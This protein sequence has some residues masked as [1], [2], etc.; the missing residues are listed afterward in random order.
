MTEKEFLQKVLMDKNVCNAINN[1][2]DKILEIIPEIKPSIGFDHKNPHHFTDVW[3]H[4]LY[5]LN[6][7]KRNLIVRTSLL[8]HDLG[9]PHVAYVGRD[10]YQH[11]KGHQALSSKFAKDIL[12]RLNF[13]K[14]D[15]EKICYIINLHDNMITDDEIKENVE[16]Q[17][18]RIE[19]QRCDC[20][21]HIE[22]IAEERMKY[23]NERKRFIKNFAKNER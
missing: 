10:G 9:K 16:L 20:M 11:F 1:N 6:L 7:S 18:L 4:T 12:S 23:V 15:I 2:L 8:L 5:A 13:D 22:P 17:K 19:V 14:D 3:G 21:A